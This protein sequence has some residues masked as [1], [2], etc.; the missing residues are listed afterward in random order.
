MQARRCEIDFNFDFPV[1]FRNAYL[2]VDVSKCSQV[3]QNM[4]SN[5]LKFTPAGGTVTMVCKL[6][7]SLG[8]S[9][10]P[11]LDEESKCGGMSFEDAHFRIEVKDT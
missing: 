5:A 11:N 2:N 9:W 10:T 7:T 4:I 1:E 6:V 3:I 8:D